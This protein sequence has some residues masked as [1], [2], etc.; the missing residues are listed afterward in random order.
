MVWIKIRVVTVVAVAGPPAVVDRE[1]GQ[2][3]KSSTDEGGVNSGGGA[4][5]Q[6]AK[7]IEICRSRSLGYQIRVQERV[8][9]DL[10]IRVIVDVYVHVFVQRIQGIGVGWVTSATWDFR[11]LD[12]GELV[13]LNPKVGFECFQRRWKTKQGRVSQC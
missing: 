13:I 7:R 4:A 1:L 8:V 12:A 5:H 2:V 10:V 6:G 3:S 11:V 9:S